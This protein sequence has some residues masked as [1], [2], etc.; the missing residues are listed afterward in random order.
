MKKTLLALAVVASAV[1]SGSALASDWT[2]NQ[3][4]GD[5]PIGGTIDAPVV[6]WQWKTGDGLSSF[7]N[8]TAQISGNVL[9]ITVADDQPF[10]A[11]R[12][13]EAYKGSL[14]G[15]S[16]IPK[17]VMT[18]Y[19]GTEITPEFTSATNMNI[20]VKVKN[21]ADGSNLGTLSVPLTFS[22][23]VAAIY[24]NSSDDNGVGS[25]TGGGTGAMLEGLVKPGLMSDV[26]IATKWSGIPVTE[27]ISYV[28]KIYP[29]VNIQQDSGYYNFND[30]NHGNYVNS[31]HAFYF[32]YG[33][34]IPANSTL[35]M[36]LDGDVSSHTEW[37]APVT[38]TVSYS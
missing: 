13:N 31:D 33:S 10:L 19:D 23:A 7:A 38:V 8:S 1:V 2:D 24:P 35:V 30:L 27:M 28:Q 29:G 21:S 15:A 34:G 36:H 32:V 20:T 5:I 16:L 18:S 9:N 22:A 6:H 17:V 12:F 3:P 4:A 37:V 26:N 14:I 11:G 25:I